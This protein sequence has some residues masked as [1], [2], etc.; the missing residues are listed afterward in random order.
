MVDLSEKE[1]TP[2]RGI[3]S[4]S[5]GD[6]Y[7]ESL[8]AVLETMDYATPHTAAEL[9][10]LPN[11][12]VYPDQTPP[13]AGVAPP[14]DPYFDDTTALGPAVHIHTGND[15][16]SYIPLTDAAVETYETLVELP[17]HPNVSLNEYDSFEQLAQEV[18]HTDDSVRAN[19]DTVTSK[20]T[21]EFS[22]LLDKIKTSVGSEYVGPDETVVKKINEVSKKIETITEEIQD[23]YYDVSILSTSMGDGTHSDPIEI[24]PGQRLA[25]TVAVENTGHKPGDTQNVSLSVDGTQVDTESVSELYGTIRATDDGITTHTENLKEVTLEW[26]P[27]D[28]D[29]GSHTLTVETDDDS[30]E[31]SI[32]VFERPYYSVEIDPDSIP[33]TTHPDTTVDIDFEVTNTGEMSEAQLLKL[34]NETAVSSVDGEELHPPETIL[35]TKSLR[36]D[37]GESEQISLRWRVDA[38]TASQSVGLRIESFDSSDTVDLEIEP[39]PVT[40][41]A[42]F[43]VTIDE[44]TRYP[45]AGETIDVDFTVTNAGEEKATKEVVLSAGGVQRDAKEITLGSGESVSPE[46]EFSNPEFELT[47][48]DWRES[49]PDSSLVAKKEVDVTI[50]NVG[51]EA[52][53]AELYLIHP[54]TERAIDNVAVVDLGA[55]ESSDEYTLTWEITDQEIGGTQSVELQ[56]WEN[57]GVQH[58]METDSVEIPEPKFELS[59]GNTY[60]Q[61]SFDDSG[62]HIELTPT[63]ANEGYAIGDAEVYLN[64]N[65]EYVDH[66]TVSELHPTDNSE[67]PTLTW[68]GADLGETL[69]VTVE[70]HDTDGTEHDRLTDTFDTPA[71]SVSIIEKPKLGLTT[72]TE[73]V[74]VRVENVSDSLADGTVRLAVDGLTED[75]KQEHQIEPNETREVEL[76]WEVPLDPP[77][78]YTQTVA[79]S[80]DDNTTSEEVS[81]FN[82]IYHGIGHVGRYDHDENVEAWGVNLDELDEEHT[83]DNEFSDET[84]WEHFDR[85]STLINAQTSAIPTDTWPQTSGARII[86]FG[87]NK[88]GDRELYGLNSTFEDNYW[89]MPVLPTT[90]LWGQYAPISVAAG[91]GKAAFMG[92]GMASAAATA[93]VS[94][95]VTGVLTGLAVGVVQAV[96]AALPDREGET[97]MWMNLTW[98]QG[99]SDINFAYENITMEFNFPAR[100]GRQIQTTH[101]DNFFTGFNDDEHEL[102]HASTRAPP[103]AGAIP[104]A[105]GSRIA[106]T[107]TVG[108]TTVDREVAVAKSVPNLPHQSLSGAI[109]E[110]LSGMWV[111]KS[112]N[113][114]GEIKRKTVKI[115]THATENYTS[116]LSDTDGPTHGHKTRRTHDAQEVSLYDFEELNWQSDNVI[117]SATVD[118][119]PTLLRDHGRPSYWPDETSARLTGISDDYDKIGYEVAIGNGIVEVYL[120]LTW[121]E[122]E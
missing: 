118:Y 33:E 40:E 113:L 96:Y 95:L 79:A 73:E 63:V 54:I 87:E 12:N 1:H 100:R 107:D 30:A 80:I 3:V 75:S 108:S 6:A 74:R 78:E 44:V 8:I 60:F 81:V 117:L 45:A 119:M 36:V 114:P 53:D 41:P 5:V 35:D 84:T 28:D 111:Q 17:S 42:H 93:G 103:S 56:V 23:P 115:G 88:D 92:V 49:T 11:P 122:V 72:E 70:V 112:V 32:T 18:S 21:A 52:G 59:E 26:T 50:T 2:L 101:V 90:T 110:F 29:A 66:K 13:L 97:D 83:V 94:L 15:W 98:V 10:A 57:R 27:S 62:N 16:Q 109:D 76:E 99:E 89:E 68:G 82:K 86:A 20:I 9:Q 43:D 4:P 102:I 55:T 106:G 47:T 7:Y 71:F 31:R 24:P 61:S 116:K 46:V 34:K 104:D 69:E 105:Q 85:D 77:E 58:D 48:T 38:D 37:S 91:V 14:E 39:V 120:N 64:V 25:V 51:P 22:E 65:G 67:W 19:I 121:L